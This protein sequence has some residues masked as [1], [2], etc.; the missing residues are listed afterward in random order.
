MT[1]F[2]YLYVVS[3]FLISISLINAGTLS[4]DDSSLITIQEGVVCSEDGNTWID[5]NLEPPQTTPTTGPFA[6]CYNPSATNEKT[7]CPRGQVCN[8]DTSQCELSDKNICNDYDTQLTCDTYTQWIAD[9]S[10]NDIKA[11]EYCG[12]VVHSWIEGANYCVNVSECSC[13]FD[14]GKCKAADQLITYCDDGSETLRGKCIYEVIGEPIDKCNEDGFMYY[15]WQGQ[16]QGPG[17]SSEC[18]ENTGLRPVPCE[19]VVRLPFFNGI[20]FVFIICILGVYYFLIIIKNS[21]GDLTNKR[22]NRFQ[23]LCL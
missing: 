13:V 6:D 10:I 2:V 1:K 16:W 20:S 11:F 23:S 8:I 3:I 22:I 18:I 12:K 19:S 14:A 5:T 7:C 4:N 17:T 9:K 21:G 15:Q